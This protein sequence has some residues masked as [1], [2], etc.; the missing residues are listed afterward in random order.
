MSTPTI[1]PGVFEPS[2]SPMRQLLYATAALLA[3]GISP[4]LFWP[5]LADRLLASNYLP[6]LYCYLG[7]PGL[8][9][10]HVIAD[11]FIGLA[12]VAISATLAY[13]I[14]KT[15]RNIPFHWMF[16][17]F[18]LFIVACGGTHFMEVVTIW[19]PVYVLSG[20]VKVFTAL[21]SVATAVLLPFTVPRVLTL[22][23]NA[24]VSEQHKRLL[25]QS[26]KR[27][28]AITE[29]AMDAIVS[30]DSRGHITY[31]NRSAERIFGYSSSEASGQPL[32]L[33]MP[34]R[35]HSAHREGLQRFLATREASVELVGKRKN[36]VEFPVSLSLS[37]W[38]T[39]GETFF[40]GIFQD[41]TERKQ[42]EKK[43]R[44][45]LEAAPDAMAV[46]NQEGK[47]VLVNAQVEKLFGYRRAD[48]V[49]QEI[50]MLV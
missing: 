36:G 15:R 38:E 1:A 47:I 20:G 5:S 3:T 13:L 17:A 43:F 24:K 8:V 28:R 37:N 22:I 35:F 33:L 18:G 50:E 6:H 29:T 49:G 9:W 40:T 14:Y 42:A 46:V 4:F 10:T 45:L 44:G 16:L 39:G 19:I 12:Y 7:K 32:T 21:V 34:E 23:Q 27:I 25:E 26:E 41:I 48:L 31:F 2:R 11:S 30:A